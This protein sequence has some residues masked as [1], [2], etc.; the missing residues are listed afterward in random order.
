MLNRTHTSNKKLNIRWS[1]WNK[2]KRLDLCFLLKEN[3]AKTSIPYIHVLTYH[4]V[5]VMRSS[6]VIILLQT[7]TLSLSQPG[8]WQ[9]LHSS[10]E[11]HTEE[12]LNL[13]LAGETSSRSRYTE[14]VAFVCLDCRLKQI[15]WSGE[16]REVPLAF[17]SKC[18]WH[19]GATVELSG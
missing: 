15:L 1:S 7:L 10:S 3:Q 13:T 12:T 8:S 18:H 6:R 19:C 11:Q 4:V 16:V 5:S 14:V 17:H 9:R 2:H